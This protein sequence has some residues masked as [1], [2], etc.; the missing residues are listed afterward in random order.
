MASAVSRPLADTVR[1]LALPVAVVFETLGL[2]AGQ[3]V[4]ATLRAGADPEALS[5]IVTVVDVL[6][7][8]LVVAL[9]AA[10]GVLFHRDRRAE[11]RR[12]RA[13]TVAGAALTA[14]LLLS[15]L[16]VL[17]WYSGIAGGW[18]MATNTDLV[19]STVSMLLAVVSLV[20]GVIAAAAERGRPGP[21]AVTLAAAATPAALLTPALGLVFRD[22]ATYTAAYYAS[23]AL[24]LL[25]LAAA[26]VASR[27]NSSTATGSSLVLDAGPTGSGDSPAAAGGQW[28]ADTVRPA[29][30]AEPERAGR[31]FLRHVATPLGMTCLVL[32]LPLM[33]AL[34]SWGLAILLIVAAGALALAAIVGAALDF[35]CLAGTGVPRAGHLPGDVAV[36]ASVLVI[37]A[38]LALGGLMG[39]GWGV[40]G[41]LV[42]GAGVAGLSAL[43]GLIGVLYSVFSGR[44]VSRAALI[45]SLATALVFIA[46]ATFLPLQDS[47]AG[48]ISFIAAGALLLIAVVAGIVTVAAPAPSLRMSLQLTWPSAPEPV[49][50]PQNP[51]R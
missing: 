50:G 25:G 37:P 30:A 44:Y 29:A 51:Y 16:Y 22:S 14:A 49:S 39:G 1:Y 17:A 46:A 42:I 7:A 38:S 5:G 3:L 33:D 21:G 45:S 35:R 48:L 34:E 12:P 11:H 2:L 4:F 36:P 32:I 15:S 40:L 26:V 6:V 9:C 43:V 23:V 10:A 31:R 19:V 24:A 18:F 41:A 28:A 47:G 27:R 20:A 8:V 13:W